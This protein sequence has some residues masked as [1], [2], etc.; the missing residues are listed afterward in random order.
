MIEVDEKW[1]MTFTN[2]VFLNKDELSCC[3]AHLTA[4]GVLLPAAPGRK[5]ILKEAIWVK[6]R[7]SYT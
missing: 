7:L 6:A 5:S 1:E 4:V 2:V 3:G